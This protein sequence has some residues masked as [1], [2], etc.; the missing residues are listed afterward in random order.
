MELAS[1]GIGLVIGKLEIPFGAGE[2]RANVMREG[3]EVA[4]ELILVTLR[5]DSLP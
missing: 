1:A 2:R 5:V 3:R 4:L